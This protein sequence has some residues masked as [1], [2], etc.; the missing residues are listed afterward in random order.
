MWEWERYLSTVGEGEI[1]ECSGNASRRIEEWYLVESTF[2]VKANL[3][4]IIIFH[5]CTNI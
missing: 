1:S 4:K 3:F 5:L 2:Y